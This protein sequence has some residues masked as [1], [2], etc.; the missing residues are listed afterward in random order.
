MLRVDTDTAHTAMLPQHTHSKVVGKQAEEPSR[1]TK[2]G[3]DRE[4]HESL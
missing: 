2:V 1:V 4:F 3:D